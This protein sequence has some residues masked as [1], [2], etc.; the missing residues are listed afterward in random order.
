VARESIL[1][2][3]YRLA[4]AYFEK[5]FPAAKLGSTGYPPWYCYV[6][7]AHVA[8]AKAERRQSQSDAGAE[9]K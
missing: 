6:V 2:R 3:Q 7:E 5:T 4:R 1:D 9:R 8:G